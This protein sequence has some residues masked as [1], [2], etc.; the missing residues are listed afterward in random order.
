[1]T[2]DDDTKDLHAVLYLAIL[3]HSSPVF[4]IIASSVQRLFGLPLDLLPSSGHVG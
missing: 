3:M 1:M 4:P 2:S